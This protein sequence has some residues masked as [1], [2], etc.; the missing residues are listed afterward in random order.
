MSEFYKQK[1]LKYKI[2]YTELQQ[3]GGAA[4]GG[5]GAKGGGSYGGGGG[6]AAGAAAGAAKVGSDVERYIEMN[7]RLRQLNSM[8]K[9]LTTELDI[10]LNDQKNSSTNST[11]VEYITQATASLS[12]NKEEIKKFMND[13]Q[14]FIMQM[15]VNEH[16]ITEAM[17]DFERARVQLQGQPELLV[18]L[19]SQ[20][21]LFLA[22]VA[23][24]DTK[25]KEEIAAE[26]GTEAKRWAARSIDRQKEIIRTTLISFQYFKKDHGL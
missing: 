25:I 22:D 23:K 19:E 13:M 3:F 7:I 1:Y 15:E 6:A 26:E 12:E 21:E 2:K 16:I 17:H 20:Q 14:T 5:S 8:N 18:S 11:I 24:L 10:L 9:T 4:A